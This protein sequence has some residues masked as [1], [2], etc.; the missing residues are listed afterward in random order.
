MLVSKQMRAPGVVPNADNTQ[1][2]I[3]T[4]RYPI[5][6]LA[7]TKCGSTFLKNLFYALDNDA[8]HPD[9]ERI[10]DYPHDLRRADKVPRWM[11][12]RGGFAFAVMRNPIDRFLSFYFDKIHRD[13]PQN[14]SDLRVKLSNTVG[15]DLS[16][17]IAADRHRANCMA[18]INWIERNLARETAE[19]INPHWRPQVA[20]LGKVDHLRPIVLRLDKL[21]AGLRTLFVNIIPDLDEKI[22]L[23]RHRNKTSYPVAK[24]SVLDDRLTARIR[25][26]YADDVARFN[27]ITPPA[28]REVQKAQEGAK[29]RLQVLSTHRFG[30]NTVVQPKVGSSYLRNLFYMLDHGQCHPDPANVDRDKCLVY[31]EKS[32]RN[33][34]RQVKFMVVR[35]PVQ[36]F[37]SLYFDK[38]WGGSDQAFPWIAEA[39]SKNRRFHARPD[40]S[41]A[42]HHDNCCRLLGYLET[43]FRSSE[44]DDLNPHWRPQSHRAARLRGLSFFGLTLDNLAP[45]LLMICGHR[46][47]D[48]EKHLENLA[49]RNSSEKPI[50]PETLASPW[51][52]ERLQDLYGEDIALYQRIKSAWDEGGPPPII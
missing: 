40:L 28:Q 9:A 49:F 33:M 50:E 20:R 30:I 47:R 37:F 7:I 12:R 17:D 18:L 19:A 31:R 14:F 11:I 21:D 4:R 15:I 26:V 25:A 22:A 39:L 38:V 10:H 45:Q 34:S 32:G 23:V 29:H 5:Y 1:K 44:I 27:A 48:L 13:H 51:I 2:F 3:T 24:E 52:M 6:C 8:L 16:P 42:E 46:T 36:R 35:D 43:K 41:E